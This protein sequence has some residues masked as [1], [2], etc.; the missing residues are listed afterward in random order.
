MRCD[1]VLLF[2]SRVPVSSMDSGNAVPYDASTSETIHEVSPMQSQN[3]VPGRRT[4]LGSVG[5]GGFYFSSSLLQQPQQQ[6]SGPRDENSPEPNGS[7]VNVPSSN[8]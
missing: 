5:L 3:Q 7:N 6:V 2:K 1:F 8:R 4:P